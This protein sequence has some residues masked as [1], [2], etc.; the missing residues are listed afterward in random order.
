[1]TVAF[2]VESFREAAPHLRRPFTPA[3]VK[4]KVQATWPKGSPTGGLIVAYIDARL[5]VERLNLICPHL[6][7]DE[8]QP[9]GNGQMWCALTLDGITRHDVGEGQGKGLV[10]DAL[11]RAAV[12]FGVGVSLYAIPKM[13]LKVEKG[14][15][16]PARDSLEM[17][18]SGETT[19]RGIYKVWLNQH[20][21][22]AF[23]EPLD[24][25]DVENAQGDPEADEPAA[26]SPADP[27]VELVDDVGRMA[28]TKAASGL[29][30]NQIKLAFTSCGLQS[31]SAIN[32]DCFDAVPLAKAGLLAEALAGVER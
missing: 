23:G 26:A 5:V 3:A 15:L 27:P 22:K 28:L 31:P 7:R 14:E 18:P 32:K 25:G 9:V 10:S 21:T 11:K 24:H 12:R 16:K 2:P 29:K 20:G 13:I 6:W 19:V 1:M 8:Y 17:T 30:A 4:F